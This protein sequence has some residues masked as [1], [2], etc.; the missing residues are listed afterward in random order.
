LTKWSFNNFFSHSFITRQG[1]VNYRF[2]NIIYVFSYLYH[3]RYFIFGIA[4]LVVLFWKRK[5][6][7]LKLIVAVSLLLYSLFLAGIDTQNPRFLLLI[8]PLALLFLF[9]AFDFLYQ[10]MAPYQ[11][12]YIVLMALFLFQITLSV[13]SMEVIW[14][15]NFL[16][17]AMA[18]QL[19]DY[20]SA[21]LYSFDIDIAM[22]GRGLDFNYKNLWEKTYETFE[23]GALLLF[24]PTK[25]EKQWKDKNPMINWK[26]LQENYDL[27][28]LEIGVDGWMLYRLN[29]KE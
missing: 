12:K 23:T 25:F 28:I 7:K 27:Q 26:Q 5:Q 1:Y 22:K 3:P 29:T 17:R 13:K 15:R 14:K 4:L 16:E 6:L 19:K 9:P 24:H 10:K 18:Q 11:G 2:P 21:T 20:E 8:F